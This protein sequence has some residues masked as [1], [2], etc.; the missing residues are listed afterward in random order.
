MLYTEPS[1]DSVVREAQIQSHRNKINRFLRRYY[2]TNNS[3]SRYG[4]MGEHVINPAI[5]KDCVASTERK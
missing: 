1:T 3:L 5:Y 2:K 4:R